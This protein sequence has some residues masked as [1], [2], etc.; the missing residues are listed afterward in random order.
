MLDEPE[1][2]VRLADADTALLEL[3]EAPE[4]W[5]PSNPTSS[6]FSFQ[7]L[8]ESEQLDVDLNKHLTKDFFGHP[9]SIQ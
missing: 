7:T 6:F 2:T 8:R 1:I 3:D 4:G 9:R 5:A